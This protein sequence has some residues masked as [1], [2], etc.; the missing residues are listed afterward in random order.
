MRTGLILKKFSYKYF[1][2][3]RLCKKN[4][5]DSVKSYEDACKVL[6][7]QPSTDF[8]NDTKDEIA[9]K[10]LKTVI[11]A[12]NEGW[13]ADYNDGNQRKWLPWFYTAGPSGFAFSATYYGCSNP[14]AGG[15]ARLC[16]KS[17]ELASYTGKQFLS[18]WEEFIL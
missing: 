7:E 14:Y 2:F 16:L 18:L 9:Y 1:N 13:K 3:N 6:G 8:G 5:K 12:L 11:K 15:A 4:I 10:K 17:E